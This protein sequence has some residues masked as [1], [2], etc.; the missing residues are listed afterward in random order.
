MLMSGL[1]EISNI[2]LNNVKIPSEKAKSI[3]P[4]LQKI[5]SDLGN[6]LAIVSDMA[7]GIAAAIKVVFPNVQHSICHYHFLRDIG[8]DLLGA[9]YDLLRRYLKSHS[10]KKRLRE[11]AKKCATEIANNPRFEQAL[12]QY[13]KEHTDG[14][15]LTALPA[16]VLAYTL[17][18]W[19]LSA[20]K[21]AQGNGFPF[22]RPQL[23]LYQRLSIV[24]DIFTQKQ[25]LH[26]THRDLKS[27]REIIRKVLGDS[28]LRRVIQELEERGAVF[29][30]LRQA[31][32]IAA[33]G[34]KDS[35]NDDGKLS[36]L[37]PIK[38]ALAAFRHDPAM[39]QQAARQRPYAKMLKQIDKYW[40]KLFANPIAISTTGG[41]KLIYPQRTNNV[42]E[43]FFRSLKRS[44]RRK[45]GRHSLNR[46][47]K[48]LLAD[49][50]LIQ[51]L[52]NDQYLKIILNGKSSLEETFANIDSRLVKDYLSRQNQ[53]SDFRL[54][55]ILKKILTLS[56]LP[57]RLLVNTLF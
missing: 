46:T 16:P 37:N 45:T 43:R 48:A 7:V 24:D 11:L 36:N 14:R 30:R 35:L 10:L 28:T 54:P 56:D 12:A 2:V 52:N 4:F 42:L 34:S 13:L 41:R 32:R 17:S 6:P 55:P 40:N 19:I 49:T 9:N 1:D 38:K 23:T 21:S 39:I 33:P 22:D 44:L 5:K 25:T 31:M 47:L 20:K 51:N 50:P 18:L 29:D 26:T 57:Q 3:I 15:P 53:S 27:L 8:K